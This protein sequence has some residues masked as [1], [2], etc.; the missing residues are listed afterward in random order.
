MNRAFIALGSNINKE[1]NM[2]LAVTIL[3]RHCHLLATS[4]VYETLPV[5]LPAQPNFFNAAVLVETDLDPASLKHRV[6]D[7]LEA[8][9]KRVRQPDK[10]APR[11]IDADLALYN[12]LVTEYD[13]HLLPDPD[14]LRFAHVAVPIADIAPDLRHPQ[15]GETMHVIASRLRGQARAANDGEPTLWLRPDVRLPGS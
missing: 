12:D 2:P 13:N 14:I 15:T 1:E 11:T 6:L 3:A 8:K 7:F 5:G 10:N 4:P 9:L